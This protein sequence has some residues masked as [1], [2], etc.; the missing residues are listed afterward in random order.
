M[1]LGTDSGASS[2]R[3]SFFLQRLDADALAAVEAKVGTMSVA[4]TWDW[5]NLGNLGIFTYV[6]SQRDGRDPTLLSSVSAN[7]VNSA[8][9]ILSQ[10]SASGFGRGIPSYYWG[11]NGAIARTTLNLMVA[12]VLAPDGNLVDGAVAELD[13]LLGRNVYGRSFVT[14]LG[15]FPPSHPHHR[16]SAATGA[17]PGLLV[18]GPNGGATA[19]TDEQGA[20]AQNEIAINWNTAMIFGAA[21]LMP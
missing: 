11:S 21:S 17:W 13:H 19:W 1:R 15:H 4:S 3:V 20:Y 18:G 10:I 14:G 2:R 12:N 16:P 9:A 8:N 7:V 5:A 6:L